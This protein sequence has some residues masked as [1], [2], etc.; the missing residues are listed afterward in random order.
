MEITYGDWLIE[1]I[2]HRRYHVEDNEDARWRNPRWG[3]LSAA[4]GV[5]HRTQGGQGVAAGAV[6]GIHSAAFGFDQ[7]GSPQLGRGDG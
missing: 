4:V 5:Q 7:P 6:E 3:K 2:L 1:M